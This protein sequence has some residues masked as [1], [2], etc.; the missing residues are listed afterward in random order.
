MRRPARYYHP[1]TILR[2]IHCY[3]E[4]MAQGKDILALNNTV[5]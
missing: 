3:N 2:Y 4:K 5:V 1:E